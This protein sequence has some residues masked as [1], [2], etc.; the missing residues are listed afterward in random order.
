MSKEISSG[1]LELLHGF[2]AYGIPNL[3][4]SK[5]LFNRVFWIG[6]LFASAATAAYYIY[7][8]L[9]SYLSYDVV[10]IIK[11]NFKQP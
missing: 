11:T 4:K 1:I 2:T 9:L 10:T 7:E 3:F 6:F 5:R 8:S